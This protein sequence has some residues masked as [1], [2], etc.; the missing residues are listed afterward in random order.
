MMECLDC[1]IRIPGYVGIQSIEPTEPSGWM[2][3]VIHPVQ[4]CLL[5]TRKHFEDRDIVP[6]EDKE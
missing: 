1:R 6:W 5:C 2:E 3:L 4:L